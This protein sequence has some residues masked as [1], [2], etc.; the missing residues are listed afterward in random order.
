MALASGSVFS[1]EGCASRAA[2]DASA[3][4]SHQGYGR[5]FLLTSKLREIFPSHRKEVVYA[6]NE[7]M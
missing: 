6:H 5:F 3:R 4:H 2:L 7:R 1:A